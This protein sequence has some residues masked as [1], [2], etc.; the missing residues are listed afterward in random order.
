MARSGKG[1]IN[2]RGFLKGAAAGAAASAATIVSGVP[3]AAQQQAAA[4]TP[5]AIGRDPCCGLRPPSR[6]WST[7]LTMINGGRARPHTGLG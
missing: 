4:G 5:P 3:A 2:R 7:Q 6:R 1:S